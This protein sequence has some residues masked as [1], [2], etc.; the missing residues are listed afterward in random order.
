[1]SKRILT[2]LLLLVTLNSMAQSEAVIFSATGGF[3]T[4]SF[5]LSLGC[6]YPN[7]H[8]RYTTDGNTPDANSTLYETPLYLDATLYSKADI[9]TI[10]ISP[11]R[12]IYIPDTIQHAIVVRAA[13]FDEENRCVSPTVTQTYL[14]D[15]LGFN[16][17]GLAV[18][19]ICADSL[20]LF[21]Y[22]TG[23][24]VPGVHWNPEWPENTGNYFQRGKEWERAVNVEFYEPDNNRGVNQTCGL[25]T[26]G[27]ISRIYPAKGMK[28]YAREEYG[29]KRFKHRFF[30][31]TPINSFK[32]LVLKPYSTNWPYSGTQNY[33]SNKVALQL[34][35]D[36]ACSRPITV[37][38]NGEYWGIYF[39]QEKMDEHYLED[40]YDIDIEQCNLMGDWYGEPE[41]GTGDGFIQM[42]DWLE[43]TFLTE[44]APYE[45]LCQQI[46]LE[47][48][49]DYMIY[50]TYISNTDWPGNNMRCWQSDDGPWRWLFFDGDLSLIDQAF[51]AFDNAVYTGEP[52]WC[53]SQQATLMFRRLLENNSF[54]ETFNA[55]V[56]ELCNGPL[57]YDSIA[58]FHKAM[59]QVLAPSID[60]QRQRFGYPPSMDYWL[61][62][63]RLIDDFLKQRTG[64]YLEAFYESPL[65]KPFDS[66]T[67]TD[68]FICFPNPSDDAVYIKMIDERSRP[69]EITVS[70]ALGRIY[71]HENHYFAP[72]ET[73]EVGSQLNPGLYIIRVGTT[74][75]RFL[76]K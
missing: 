70:D 73:L 30:E 68:D 26:H 51:D 40:H 54:K 53:N 41:Y 32:H 36:A 1:M 28:I 76:K 8:V 34:G 33:L 9:Y 47:N 23:I 44:N 72:C 39:L 35:L 71:Y 16:A 46:D 56:L 61:W 21:D 18:L 67:S 31:D 14:I 6:Y 7:H 5:P 63:N 3:Y 75:Q 22:E 49:V 17:Q 55:R 2:F 64:T 20:D 59:M 13:V 66:P 57:Q 10:Q 69:L 24:F 65:F 12:L 43:N 58:P 27:H 52:T 74:Y 37:F 19:S 4:H 25:R 38:I 11:E 29:K 15:E 48:F 45:A 60:N 42:M 62:A 50:E